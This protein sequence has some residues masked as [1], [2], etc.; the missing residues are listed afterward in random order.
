MAHDGAVAH[1][2]QCECGDITTDSQL[3]NATVVTPWLVDGESQGSNV[4]CARQGRVP[5]TD[6]G[7]AA[8]GRY[9]IPWPNAGAPSGVR[10]NF[11]CKRCH[12]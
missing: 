2:Q 5:R 6:G 4:T 7:Q 11:L 12:F 1:K 10:H 8:D 9:N 3:P